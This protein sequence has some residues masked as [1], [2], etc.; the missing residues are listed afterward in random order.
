MS[1]WALQMRDLGLQT[2]L[3][4]S[5][6]WDEELLAESIAKVEEIINSLPIGPPDVFLPLVR[7]ELSEHYN[8]L[9]IKIFEKIIKLELQKFVTILKAPEA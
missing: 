8:T 4:E 5:F 1:Y 6:N 9:Q 7:A 3:L 2:E